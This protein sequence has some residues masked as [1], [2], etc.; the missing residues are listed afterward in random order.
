VLWLDPAF[1]SRDDGPVAALATE[2]GVSPDADAV[3]GALQ[4][5]PTAVLID[6]LHCWLAPG[7]RGFE[8][9]EA[10]LRV[11]D[12]AASA[13]W[14]VA[15]DDAAFTLLDEAVPLGHRFRRIL[16]TEPLDWRGLQAIFDVREQLGGFDT[17]YRPRTLL[18][19]AAD[20]VRPGHER[21]NYFRALASASAGDPGT[22]LAIHLDAVQVD[23][24]GAL[25]VGTPERPSLPFV[26]QLGEDGL[27]LLAGLLRYGPMGPAQLGTLLGASEDELVARIGFLEH[28]GLVAS[29][30]GGR[31]V[32]VAPRVVPALRRELVE[33]A[34]LPGSAP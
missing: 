34:V 20:R 26:G 29:A 4:R 30:R 9:L 14:L 10:L 32:R 2:L 16:A 18:A 23:D 15:V 33:L 31:E 1:A 11:I 21:E 12:R 22:A 17:T 28:A 3:L 25:R 6:D 27:A 5:E 13:R 24:G 19:R 8:Q 7:P